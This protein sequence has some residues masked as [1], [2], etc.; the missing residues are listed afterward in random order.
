[1]LVAGVVAA[2]TLVAAGQAE[3]VTVHCATTA[4]V[5]RRT[6]FIAKDLTASGIPAHDPHGSPCHIA[7]W[8]TYYA[9]K[10]NGLP[11]SLALDPD[12]QPWAVHKWAAPGNATSDTF[13]HGTERVTVVLIK[14]M[15]T[16]DAKRLARQTLDD[17]EAAAHPDP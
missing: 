4:P 1:M 2:G 15:S 9:E 17:F 3:A 11:S 10:Q 13:T 6:G 7:N 14:P 5:S 12:G 8:L 16:K